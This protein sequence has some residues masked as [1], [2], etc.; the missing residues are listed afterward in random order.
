MTETL[1]VF[2]AKAVHSNA[3]HDASKLEQR[4]DVAMFLCSAVLYEVFASRIVLTG[5]MRQAEVC[6][7]EKGKRN[8]RLQI[9]CGGRQAFDNGVFM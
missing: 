3:S 6:V 2:L 4:S 8:T 5:Q 1:S 7:N 9:E